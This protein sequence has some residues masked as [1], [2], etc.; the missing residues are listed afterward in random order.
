M[1]FERL[2]SMGM[3]RK[4]DREKQEDLW[5]A[6]SEIVTTPGHVFYERLKTV[7]NAEKFDQRVEAICRKYYKS[8]SGRPSITPG[9]YFRLLLLGYFE[10][11]DSERGIAWRCAD[12]SSL[13]LFLG[14]GIDQSTPDH[15]TI[16]RT[17][18]LIDLQTHQDV[19]QWVLKLLAR[20][21]LVDGKPAG[22]DSTTLEA[23]AAMKS[24]VRRDTQESYDQ[25]LTGLA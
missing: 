19:F 2:L 25:F 9:T 16:S 11:I 12:S 5:V 18:R 8:S 24:I 6:F 10:G 4:R 15:S 20:Q 23:N 7:L 3:G 17:R 14:Y 22:I 13:R 21:G 1:C